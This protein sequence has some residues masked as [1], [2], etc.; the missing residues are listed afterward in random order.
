[1]CDCYLQDTGDSIP[2]PGG[3]ASPM[4]QHIRINNQRP[5]G[6]FY[7]VSAGARMH[8]TKPNLAQD[9]QTQTHKVL[10]QQHAHQ[11]PHNEL[12]GQPRAPRAKSQE[13]RAKSQEPRAKSH[14]NPDANANAH[15]HTEAC[16]HTIEEY[17][18]S[19]EN[20]DRHT[21]MIIQGGPTRAWTAD[22]TVI[23]RTH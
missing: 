1:M 5:R 19:G 15:A 4:S 13:P 21:D 9:K 2:P 10:A 18:Q 14:A 11:K 16:L 7:S 23:S 6:T 12:F 22:L 17:I 8:I 20:R 3:G